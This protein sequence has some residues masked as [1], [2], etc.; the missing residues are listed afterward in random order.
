V[1]MLSDEAFDKLD[2]NGTSVPDYMRIMIAN[3]LA[4]T[5]A[6]WVGSMTKSATGTYNSQ[7]MVVDYKLFEPG[8]SL[9]NGTLWV[10]EQ[11]PGV[12][13]SQDATRRLQETGFWASE[14]RGFFADERAVDGET[15][16]EDMHGDLFSASRNP[17]ANIFAKT[18]PG[19]A[20]LADMRAEMRRNHWPHE[21]DGG[22]GNTPDHAIAARGDLSKDGPAPNGGVDSKVTSACLVRAL[23]ADAIN[24]P[25]HEG[26]PAFHWLDTATGRDLYP[27]YPHDGLPDLWNFGWVRMTPSGELPEL[28]TDA[29]AA[30][31]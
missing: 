24:G 18:A 7:W 8:R 17:R 12:S 6:E 31:P 20:S 9:K 10:L 5:G 13:H 29:C 26:L 21:V 3:R 14:N 22:P 1:S 11:A 16:A 25:T 23:A 27:D 30:S 4:R 19:V 15:D 2:D 28:P